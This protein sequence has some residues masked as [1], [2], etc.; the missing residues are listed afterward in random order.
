MVSRSI[1]IL[2][3]C[4]VEYLYYAHYA[5]VL[6]E[7]SHTY[8]IRVTTYP[9]QSWALLYR[10]PFTPVIFVKVSKHAGTFCKS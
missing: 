9:G 6:H 1:F 7:N 10:D 4:L 3:S 2:Y 5:A 8:Q